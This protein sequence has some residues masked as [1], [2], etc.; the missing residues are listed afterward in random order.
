MLSV[1][2]V[3]VTAQMAL[4]WLPKDCE[5]PLFETAAL[6]ASGRLV[7]DK[8]D[9]ATDGGSYG[10]VFAGT[11]VDDTGTSHRMCAKRDTFLVMVDLFASKGRQQMDDDEMQT[12]YKRVRNDLTAAWRLLGDLHVVNYLAITTTTRQVAS[13]TVVL[14][15]YFIMEEEGEDL[16]KWLEQHPP[17]AENRAAFEGYVRCVLE[18][19]AALHSAGITHRDLNPRNVVICRHDSSMAKIIDLGLAKPEIE[20]RD[21]AA[22]SMTPG[23]PWFMAPEFMDPQR[24]SQAVDVW[25]VGVMCAEWLLAEQLGREE[26]SALLYELSA[27]PNGMAAVLQRLREAVAASMSPE[28]VLER[29]ASAALE[30]H[31][32]AR[33]SSIDLATTTASAVSDDTKRDSLIRWLRQVRHVLQD[34]VVGITDNDTREC[35]T[36]FLD[37]ESAADITMVTEQLTNICEAL[38]TNTQGSQQHHIARNIVQSLLAYSANKHEEIKL[39]RLLAKVYVKSSSTLNCHRAVSLCDR[40]IE[41]NSSTPGAEHPSAAVTLPIMMH[42]KANALAK[43]GGKQNVAEAITLYDRVIKINTAAFGEDHPLS[44]GTRRRKANVLVE[45][46]GAVN[47]AAAITLYDRVIEI[48]TTALGADHLSTA[49]ALQQKAN[50]LV[51]VGGS[52]NLAAA[53]EL[54]D[55]AIKIKTAALGPQHTETALTLQQKANALAKMGGSANHTAAVALY[56]QVIEINTAALGADHPEI[57]L[58]LQYKANVLVDMAGSANVAAAIALYDRVIE[59]KTAAHGP[60]HSETAVALHRKA[61][62][63]MA[64]GGSANLASAIRLYDRVLVINTVSLG[65]DRPAHYISLSQKTTALAQMGGSAN[66]VEAAALYDRVIENFHTLLGPEHWL[67]ATAL[68]RK[69]AVLLKMGGSENLAA[70]TELYDRVL[71]ITTAVMGANHPSTFWALCGKANALVETGGSLNLVAAVGMCDRAIEVS[72]TSLGS[73]WT[74]AALQQKAKAFVKMAGPANIAAAIALYD[75]V[76]ETR[77]AAQGA[78]HPSTA[79]VLQQKANALVEMGGSANLAAAVAL[80]DRVIE[81]RSTVLGP[82]HLETR[83][84]QREKALVKADVEPLE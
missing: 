60:D 33:P 75:R 66:L 27:G 69:A 34:C 8:K 2:G 9:T 3:L 65:T 16:H 22:N 44:V 12:F 10:E 54:C 52:A 26:A 11:Y 82:D 67:T 40:A 76:I 84:A 63:L 38:M 47:V 19:L 30:S 51:E 74:A 20:F 70:A 48:N 32:S 37:T 25:A 14:P 41:L 83:A 31:P 18:G 13:G 53:I 42:Q 21:K 71:E 49:T 39:L 61:N 68:S 78:D 29:V 46:G 23:S 15:E 79:T 35:I 80:Y 50:A 4:P 72:T 57:A 17:C 62:A 56:D 6:E 43:L 73:L 36:I 64:L 45:M 58:T 7:F 77:T 81:I 24:A 5:F 1:V 28:S 55:R 59:I